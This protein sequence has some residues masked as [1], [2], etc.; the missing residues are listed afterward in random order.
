[1]N[2]PVRCAGQIS[3]ARSIESKDVAAMKFLMEHEVGFDSVEL[4]FPSIQGCIAIV[5][6]TNN[7][8]FGYHSYGGSAAEKFKQRAPKFREFVDTAGGPAGGTRLYGITFVGNNQRGYSGV[9]RQTWLEELAE[10]ASKLEYVGKISG[11]DLCKTIKGTG[12]SAY[13]EYKR[14]GSKC[15][16]WVREWTHAEQTSKPARMANPNPLEHKLIQTQGSTNVKVAS[17]QTVVT[18]VNRNGLTKISKEQLR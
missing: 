12:K 9:A 18:G 13:V 16:V 5:Y 6:Q 2:L 14:N 11:Y 3:C 7:G 8:L 10:Y 17:L 15:D 1:L 4:G